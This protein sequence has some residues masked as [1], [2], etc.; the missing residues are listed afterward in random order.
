MKCNNIVFLGSVD[1]FSVASISRESSFSLRLWR[2]HALFLL[3]VFHQRRSSSSCQSC[4]RP[5][6][7]VSKF[8]S[9]RQKAAKTQLCATD[10]PRVDGGNLHQAH[11]LFSQATRR[12][13]G[14]P[15]T[16]QRVSPYST[17]GF[18]QRS[19]SRSTTGGYFP[20]NSAAQ[21][22]ANRKCRF[23]H[24]QRIERQKSIQSRG[25][26]AEGQR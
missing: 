16:H 8:E 11:C 18:L 5:S 22:L 19:S 4:R 7:H 9:R 10:D 26:P 14:F 17:S 3:F 25:H 21:S 24:N 6:S 1:Q 15:F 12:R 2:F 20:R 13:S 23:F